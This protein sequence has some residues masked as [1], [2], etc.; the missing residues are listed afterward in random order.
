MRTALLAL[1][2]LAPAAAPGATK[3]IV[4]VVEQKTGKPVTDLKAADFVITDGGQVRAVEEA[5]FRP[6]GL[7]D[8]MLMLDTS[9]VGGMVQ[10][11]AFG[12][13]EQLQEK[14]QMAVVSF[15]SS[16]DMI[17]EFTS[18]KDILKRSVG[19]VKYGNS[20]HLLDALYA[21]LEGG[22]EGSS[23]RRV[24]LL[25]TAGID[26]PSRVPEKDV[27]RL[28]RRNQVSI[29]PVYVAGFGRSLFE[30]L[31]RQT[32]GASFSLR[33]MSKSM[34]DPMPRVFEVLRSSY[35]VSIQGNLGLSDRA[36]IEIRRPEKLAA[37]FLQLD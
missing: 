28:A 6:S 25:V 34:K 31:A 15:H 12:A 13:I 11:V 29:Y 14:D 19:S 18:S 7:M 35:Q 10:P 30:L 20:P 17:Q 36:K 1:F 9:L 16:A 26:G 27:L 2:C 33:E 37:S 8:V 22:F 32:G 3:L 23:F 24:I 21:T 4:T 5:E